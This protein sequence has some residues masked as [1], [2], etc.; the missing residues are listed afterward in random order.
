M[1]IYKQFEHVACLRCGHKPLE[2][3]ACVWDED[4]I[5][6]STPVLVCQTKGGCGGFF[7]PDEFGLVDEELRR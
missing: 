1:I 4:G 5:E 2:I 6:K 7:D 3:W